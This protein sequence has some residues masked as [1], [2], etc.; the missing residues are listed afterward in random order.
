VTPFEL[1]GFSGNLLDRLS[2]ARDNAVALASLRESI[3]ARAVA[4]VG[5]TPVLRSESDGLAALHPLDDLRAL[6]GEE[7]PVLL[8]RDAAGPVYGLLLPDA[9]LVHE[10]AG[11]VDAFCDPRESTVAGRPELRLRN[12]RALAVETALPR[13]Q[14]AIL[15][16]AKAVLHWHANHRFCARCGS[17]TRAAQ[18]GWRRDCPGCGAQHFPRTDPVVI[19]LATHGDSC[20]MGRQKPFPPGMYSCLAGFVECGETLEEAARREIFEES[21]VRL[22]AV[23]VLASQPW[24]FPASLMI[25]CRAEALSRDIVMDAHELEDCRWFPREEVRAMTAGSHPLSLQAPHPIAI[26][27]RLLDHW[28][29]S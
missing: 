8:G 10:P 16:Q 20:L 12:L 4:F 17:P 22:G 23:E 14:I 9:T 25:G 7:E 29:K 21:G 26:A 1:I 13:D 18:A 15:A 3:G 11:A 2:E 28:L 5:A 24:P 19:V 6:A 27:R